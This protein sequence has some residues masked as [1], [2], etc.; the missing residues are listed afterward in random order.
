MDWALRWRY[1]LAGALVLFAIWGV[2]VLRKGDLIR[3]WPV[4]PLAIWAVV[5][6]AARR[7]AGRMR[8][9]VA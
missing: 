2:E 4:V 8:R 9:S 6:A 5:L 7:R 1:W 3:P